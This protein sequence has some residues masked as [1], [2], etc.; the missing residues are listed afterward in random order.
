MHDLAEVLLEQVEKVPLG[1]ALKGLG[2]KMPAFRKNI[3]GKMRGDLAEMHR[4][5]MVGT[6]MPGGGRRHVRDDEVGRAAELALNEVV[7]SIE[8]GNPKDAK[9]LATTMAILIDK[10]QLLSGGATSRPNVD[11]GALLEEARGKVARLV[12]MRK[13]G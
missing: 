3:N 2:K 4:A 11:P 12:P 5:Q 1:A 8:T 13:V 9:D 6:L 10:A 7:K